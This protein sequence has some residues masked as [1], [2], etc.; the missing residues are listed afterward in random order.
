VRAFVD[1]L[2]AAAVVARFDLEESLRSRRVLVLL[3]LYAAGATGAAWIFTELLQSLEEELA[4]ALLV[5][6]T[7]TPGSLTEA[8][9]ESPEVRRIVT[10]WVRDPELAASLLRQPPIAL[11]YFWFALTFAPAFVVLTASET[12]S[13]EIASGSVRFALFR[14]DR[15][16]WALGKLL[17]QAALLGVGLLLGAVGAYAV[18]ALRLATF[19]PGPTAVHL[20]R[21]AATGFV[22]AFAFLGLALGVSQVTRSVPKARALGLG[23][24]VAILVLDAT[25]ASRRV[26]EHVPVL[27]GTLRD[28]FPGPHRM[29]LWR[30]ELGAVL[31]ATAMLLGL[32]LVLFAAG[33]ARFLRTD[34]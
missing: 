2:R 14:T 5:A 10:R 4:A 30:P 29:E 24:Y 32:G 16:S 8:L 18:G 20:L 7:D 23:L 21:Y 6:R 1:G 9:M 11:L 17:G 25:L 3:L 13:A 33:H 22:H 19:A 15:G 26:T 34:A 27:A 28:L 12:I 31:P